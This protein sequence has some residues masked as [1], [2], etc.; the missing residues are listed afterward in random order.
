MWLWMRAS[1]Y[2][3]VVGG[4]WLFLLPACVL[5]WECGACVLVFRSWPWLAAGGTLLALGVCLALWA[6]YYL[7]RY[8]LGTPLPLDPPTR[9]VTS[10]PY[11]FIRNP[12]ALA[13]V[14]M[15]VGE[16]LILQSAALWALIPL[17][18]IYLELL[19]GPFES[20]QLAKEF[21]ADYAAYAVRVRKWVPHLR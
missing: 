6:G 4:G 12:Q 9:L 15:V 2:M 18:I 7:I 20:R 3:G 13:M 1:F 14:L 5:Y 10:G 19:V 16:A 17:T 11:R 21:G 8:G